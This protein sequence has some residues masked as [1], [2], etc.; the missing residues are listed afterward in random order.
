MADNQKTLVKF[1]HSEQ[2]PSGNIDAGAIWF[3]PGNH[4]IRIYTGTDWQRYSGV[5][6]EVTVTT[7][8]GTQIQHKKAN[9][10]TEQ[11]TSTEIQYSNIEYTNFDGT[12]G[13]LNAVSVDEIISKFVTQDT[14]IGNIRVGEKTGVRIGTGITSRDLTNQIEEASQTL[15]GAMSTGDKIKLDNTTIS[16]VDE[17]GQTSQ[18]KFEAKNEYTVTLGSAA[19]KKATDRIR[20]EEEVLAD[21]FVDDRIPTEKAVRDAIS[22]IGTVME[23]KGVV[24]NLP[25]TESGMPNGYSVGDLVIYQGQEYVLSAP[26]DGESGAIY[27]QKIGD[28]KENE[29]VLSLNNYAG[30]VQF[31]NSNDITFSDGKPEGAESGVTQ[32]G[33]ITVTVNKTDPD[34]AKGIVK[35]SST[36]ASAGSVAH[37]IDELRAIHEEDALVTSAAL[38]DL[39]ARLS[40]EEQTVIEVADV[41]KKTGYDAASDGPVLIDVLSQKATVDAQDVTTYV[42]SP[43]VALSTDTVN[44]PNTKLV[45]DGYLNEQVSNAIVWQTF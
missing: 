19:T 3:N 34:S 40:A 7:S 27:W 44:Y 38:N 10:I 1:Y 23:F 6:K 13:N 26:A 4:E 41:S 15:K 16:I 31:T 17:S 21:N 24:T 11:G 43:K 22:R 33:S 32:G 14:V 20:S 12:K 8:D 45:T 39:N 42:V 9:T 5:V 28:V 35:G 2:F 37:A 30:N 36:I 29:A 18:H 25:S